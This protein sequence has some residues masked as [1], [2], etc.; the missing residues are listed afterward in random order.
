MDIMNGRDDC[1]AQVIA[2]APGH[3]GERERPERAFRGR[4]FN[5]LPSRHPTE[6]TWGDFVVCRFHWCVGA[7]VYRE[8]SVSV[9]F[10]KERA[11]KGWALSVSLLG[12]QMR[13]FA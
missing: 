13:V 4:G 12:T 2:P 3:S 11:A 8:A 6:D 1:R 10:S 5:G 9:P 7:L